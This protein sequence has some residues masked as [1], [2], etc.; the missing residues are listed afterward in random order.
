VKK[1]LAGFSATDVV[2]LPAKKAPAKKAPRKNVA[3]PAP[4]AIVESGAE[5]TS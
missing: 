4:V 3:V 5:L 1:R 2:K